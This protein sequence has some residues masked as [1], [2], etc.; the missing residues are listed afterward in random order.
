MATPNADSAVA[1]VAMLR[2]ELEMVER[3]LDAI[4]RKAALLPAVIAAIAGIFIAPDSTF[5]CTQYV[6]LVPGLA[7]GITAS[8]LALVVMKARRLDVGPNAHATANGAHFAPAEFN[9]RV[10]RSLAKSVKAMSELSEW[11]AERLNI[12]GWFAGTS[13]L[14]FA[15]V[16]VAGGFG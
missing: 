8:I 1:A 2:A 12:A 16:R 4:D 14:L 9:Q 10:A 5:T 15:L 7:C 3:A 13:I 11:K 6:A